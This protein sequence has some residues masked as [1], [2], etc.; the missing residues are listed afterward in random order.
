MTEK[1]CVFCGEAGKMSREHL[2]PASIYKRNRE[3]NNQKRT[4]SWLIKNKKEF[5]AEVVIKDVCEPCNNG[6]LS[7][8][9]GYICTMFDE[10]F[11]HMPPIYENI[12]FD[13]KYHLLKRWLLKTCFNSSRANNSFDREALENFTPYILGKNDALGKSAQLFLALSYPQEYVAENSF[14]GFNY[15][16]AVDDNKL[17]YPCTNRVGFSKATFPN[18][19]EKI[20]RSV[21]MRSY[22]FFIALWNPKKGMSEQY[23]FANFFSETNR[24][25]QLKS[26]MSSININC[27]AIGAWDS[28]KNSRK[29]EFSL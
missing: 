24:V 17:V 16:F 9:D 11:F 10:Y 1:L 19:G 18:V 4:V 25:V 28:L 5:P 7:C 29:Y 6:T 22:S 8:L 20:L 12:S 26:N 13:F 3:A 23:D 14:D 27:S 21:H 2:F 15:E